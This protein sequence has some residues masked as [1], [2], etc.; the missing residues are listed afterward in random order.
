MVATA[1]DG[2]GLERPLK[3]VKTRHEECVGNFDVHR[4]DVHFFVQE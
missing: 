1:V 4:K 3:V 2:L